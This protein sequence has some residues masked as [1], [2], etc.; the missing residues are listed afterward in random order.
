MDC[1]SC[2]FIGSRYAT[3]SIKNQLAEAVEK[4]IN[5]YGVTTFTV[6]RYGGFDRLTMGV[7]QEAKRL[8]ENIKIYLLAPY[9]FNQKVEAP[10][11]FDGTFY[12][13]GLEKTPFRLAIV[14]ANHLMIKTSDYLIAYPGSG[15][16][17]KI[18]EY[19]QRREKR[20]LIKVTLLREL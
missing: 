14:Q 6:G 5:E 17:L 11:G 19:A 3:S 8:H 1:K 13:E 9:A 20:G 2:F 10:E 18:T 16:S 4:H 7:L 12:P 15:N